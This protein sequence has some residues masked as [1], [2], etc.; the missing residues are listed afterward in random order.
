MHPHP[1]DPARATLMRDKNFRWLMS[2]AVIS[3]LGDQ[4]TLVA[5]PWLVLRLTGDTLVLGTVLGLMSLP[6]ALFILIGGAV[7][8]RYSPKR[9]LML[10]KYVNTLLLAALAGLVLTG[11]L[12]LW[13]VYT[14]ALAIGLATAFSI[15][16]AT[17][18]LPHVMARAQLPAANSLM[19]GLRQLSMFVGPLLAGVLIAL[20]GDGA[21]GN[22]SGTVPDALGLG[23]AFGLDALSFAVSAWTLAQVR[24]HPASPAAQGAGPAAHEPVFHAVKTGL[25]HLWQDQDLR[26]CFIYW[27]AVAVLITGPVQIAM[28]VLASTLQ[29]GAAALGILLG[30]HGAGTLVGMAVSGARPGLRL[31]TLGL[32]MLS[33]D[34]LVGLLFMPMG[35][36][37]ATWQGATLLGAIGVLGGFMQVAI[38][39]WLQQRTPAALMGRVM[40]MFMF[41]FLGLAPLS[42]AVTGWAMRAITLPQ[43]FLGCGGLLLCLALGAMLTSPLRQVTDAIT[44]P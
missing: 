43:L 33:I 1:T 24:L 26:R 18:M 10:T 28:P 27:A 41:I 32:T 20:F 23:V 42:G 4:F 34:A 19:M 8:D 22:A 38:F 35:L 6:R 31:G 3:M 40:S 2:G 39:S 11:G 30:A 25:R 37:T 15:P 21:S 12:A 5:L 29:L 44:Q 14:L 17:S 13:T 36:I 7:V 9:V 16:S